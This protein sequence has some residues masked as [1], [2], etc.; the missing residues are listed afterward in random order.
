MR[1]G[2]TRSSKF[3][4]RELQMGTLANSDEHPDVAAKPEA[5]PSANE[6]RRR[7]RADALK[8]AEGLWKQ[9]TDIPNDGAE[10]QDQLRA[11][12]R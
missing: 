7:R 4:Y 9:R 3:D 10:F 1:L 11:E 5:P 6:E 12:W 2:C 8:A